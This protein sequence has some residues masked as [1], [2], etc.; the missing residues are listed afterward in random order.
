MD[1]E[2][3]QLLIRSEHLREKSRICAQQAA[4]VNRRLVACIHESE[5]IIAQSQAIIAQS[6]EQRGQ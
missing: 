3:E 2:T 1:A 4:S 5:V 6:I